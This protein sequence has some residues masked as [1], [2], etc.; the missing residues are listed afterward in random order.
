MKF[1]NKKRLKQ[2][3]RHQQ[4]RN[5][6]KNKNNKINFGTTKTAD[7]DV[8][9]ISYFIFISSAYFFMFEKSLCGAT[10]SSVFITYSR[11][12]DQ[13]NIAFIEQNTVKIRIIDTLRKMYLQISKITTNLNNKPIIKTN[14]IVYFF[15][16][17]LMS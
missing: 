15:K 4:T 16:E 11:L 10:S 7:Y 5:N 17:Q 14:K 6:K 12:I 13:Y 2:Q 8:K 1:D 9:Y 3:Q